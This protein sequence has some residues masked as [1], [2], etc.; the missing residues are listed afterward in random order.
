MNTFVWSSLLLSLMFLSTS[1]LAQ[2][3]RVNFQIP[4]EEVELG[5]KVGNQREVPERYSLTELVR[6]DEDIK[7]WSELVTIHN[8]ALP[9]GGHTLAESVEGAFNAVKN[10][11]ELQCPGSKEWNVLEKSETSILYEWISVGP[12][13]PWPKQHEIAKLLF[14][15]S[16]LFQ[17]RYTIKTSEMPADKRSRWIKVL[18]EAHVYTGVP[19]PTPGRTMESELMDAATYVNRGITYG[20]KG[21]YDQ[22]ISDFNKA[23]EINPTLTQ[24]YV[25]RGIAYG[26]K[27]QHDQAISDYNKALELD[28]RNAGAY[29]Y[30]GLAYGRKG[31][32]DQAISD[33]SKALE[34]NPKLA[35]AYYN[36]GLAYYYFRKDY[37]KARDDVYKAQGLGVKIDPVIL[38]E[39]REKSGREK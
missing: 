26:L 19:R 32:Y 6:K 35:Q 21:Q 27:G 36:R 11:L 1:A 18:S 20:S 30:R 12:C 14:G 22:A 13:D 16:N 24:A 37:D 9:P 8:F 29:Y 7:S 25:N 2:E 5:W 4:K 38:K 31:Q 23:L 34:I 17:L 3:E 33:Y 28:P 39:L 15:K 10:A